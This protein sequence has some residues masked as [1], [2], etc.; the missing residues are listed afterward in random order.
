M[1]MENRVR[2]LKQIEFVLGETKVTIIARIE[3]DSF[4]EKISSTVYSQRID[5]VIVKRSSNERENHQ[6]GFC[7]T[8]LEWEKIASELKEHYTDIGYKIE[9][10][11]FGYVEI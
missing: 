9:E 8:L 1:N 6:K 5:F 3:K 4:Y 7:L 11:L 2:F 10:E